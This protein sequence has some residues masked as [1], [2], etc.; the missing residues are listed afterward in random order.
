MK[1]KNPG[2]KKAVCCLT[3]VFVVMMIRYSVSGA[4]VDTSVPD[5]ASKLVN[6]FSNNTVM[7]PLLFVGV[8]YLLGAK[9]DTSK[10]Y[11]ALTL[12]GA[13][14]FALLYVLGLCCQEIGEFMVLFSHKPSLLMLVLTVAAYAVVFYHALSLLWLWMEKGGEKDSEPCGDN[15]PFPVL[16]VACI[17]FLCWLP[18]L[19]MNYPCSFCNDATYSLEQWVGMEP[20]TTATPPLSTVIM[21]LCYSVGT[22]LINENFGTF[23]Y[24]LLHAVCGAIVFALCIRE[25][26]ISGA[27]KQF[28]IISLAFFALTPLWGL[29]VQ[30]Y[31]KD[32]LYTVVF[33]LAMTL[34]LPVVRKRECSARHASILCFVVLIAALLRASALMEL[35]PVLFLVAVWLK[36]DARKWLLSAS[37]TSFALFMLINVVL[38]PALGINKLR[39]G[40]LMSAPFMQ[41]ARYCLTYP[42]EVTPEEREAISAVLPFDEFESRYDP[43]VSDHIKNAYSGNDA[44]LPAYFKAWFQMFMKHP[45]NYL[46]THFTNHWLDLTPVEPD[47]HANILSTFGDWVTSLGPYRVFSVMPTRLFI[48]IR[49]A[50][51]QLPLVSLLA[52]PGA[53]TWALWICVLQ[54]LRKKQY[55]AIFIA[56][57]GLMNILFCISSPLNGSMRYELP[58]VAMLPLMLAWT[59]VCSRK[60][61]IAE[62]DSIPAEPIE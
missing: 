10:T 58:T 8:F 28:C 25:C 6:S 49:A 18:W 56:V 35:F 46:E 61:H 29:F 12:A 60:K 11:D 21:G 19:L 27:S 47:C 54:L 42:D 33:V 9:R 37:V 40:E 17:I 14:F 62:S 41:T 48:I 2:L 38:F 20:W 7:D 24:C 59:V 36:K 45:A 53:Y 43:D 13:V 26:R 31:V 52:T 30:W 15:G 5:M 22:A 57:P 50:F 32:F 4:F 51:V 44:A 23:L 34:L 39:S 16:K 55:S 1:K 3:S